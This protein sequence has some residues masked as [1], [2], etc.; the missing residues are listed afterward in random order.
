MTDEKTAEKK[1]P[2][3]TC[4]GMGVIQDFKK[5]PEPSTSSTF[6]KVNKHTK[7]CPACTK[8]EQKK[9]PNT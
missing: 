7:S 6:L 2:C 8:P 3:A 9:K 1:E 4:R 5:Y